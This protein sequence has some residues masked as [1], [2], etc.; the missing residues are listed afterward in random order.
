MSYYVDGVK[1]TG[2]PAGLTTWFD[3]ATPHGAMNLQH[4][5]RTLYWGGWNK[6]AGLSGP[7]MAD[8][9]MAGRSRSVQAL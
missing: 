5:S 8:S 2:L 4:V 3:G 7:T 9:V 1:L 6:H